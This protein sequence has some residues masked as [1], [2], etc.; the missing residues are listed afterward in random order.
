MKKIFAFTFLILS[1]AIASAQTINASLVPEVVKNK[2]KEMYPGVKG[3]YWKQSD[4]GFVE[5]NFSKDGKKCTTLFVTTGAWVSTDC[6]ITAEQL[7][8]NAK[9][10]LDDPNHADK[11]TRYFESDTKAK[12]KQFSADI[13]KDGQS[14]QVIFD[15]EGNL[16]MKG[17]KN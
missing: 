2:M 6:E 8:V 11:V 15:S 4:A 1:A 17:P 5:A 9:A 7:P 12:G 10:Y 16:I 13:R 14:L 3:L